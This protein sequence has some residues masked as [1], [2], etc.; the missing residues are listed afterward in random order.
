MSN[1]DFNSK[2]SYF[3]PVTLLEISYSSFV[4]GPIP[5]GIIDSF[6]DVLLEFVP[7]FLSSERVVTFFILSV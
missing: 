2:L 5:E 1:K 3:N 7:D 4:N 6:C